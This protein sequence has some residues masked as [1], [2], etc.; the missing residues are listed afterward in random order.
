MAGITFNT[1]LIRIYRDRLRLA[2]SHADTGDANRNETLSGLRFRTAHS[3]TNHTMS[4]SQVSHQANEEHCAEQ[5][6]HAR[7]D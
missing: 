5:D 6:G 3:A 7:G 2:D 4:E 1:I